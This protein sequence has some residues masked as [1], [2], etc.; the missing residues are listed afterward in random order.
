MRLRDVAHRF[1]K[2]TPIDARILNCHTRRT[3]PNG[4]RVNTNASKAQNNQPEKS[5][6]L[7]NPFHP[8]IIEKAEIAVDAADCFYSEIRI[9][10][11]LE[12]ARGKKLKRKEGFRT[13]VVLW[14]FRTFVQLFNEVNNSSYDRRCGKHQ[15]N[16]LLA[17]S[18][19]LE[20]ATFVL[21]DNPDSIRPPRL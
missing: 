17:A 15:N 6:R 14:H 4:L 8:E 16:Q 9:E 7:I 3:G 5:E 21:L 19:R 13:D 10:N 11:T 12:D 20:S 18:R 2:V 1:R